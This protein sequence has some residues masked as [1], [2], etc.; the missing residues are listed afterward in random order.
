MTRAL[1][2]CILALLKGVRR[3]Q[4]Q[5]VLEVAAPGQKLATFTFERSR[6][7]SLLV[8]LVEQSSAQDSSI[9]AATAFERASLYEPNCAPLIP[10]DVSSIGIR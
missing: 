8:T 9:R 3:D 2:L 4:L 7:D 10:P 6:H 1:I 5:F